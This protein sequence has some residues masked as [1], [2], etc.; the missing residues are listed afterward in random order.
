MTTILIIVGVIL[1]IFI[2]G[3]I[4]GRVEKYQNRKR[5]DSIRIPDT[6][7]SNI[8]TCSGVSEW[9]LRSQLADDPTHY[10]FYFNHFVF[11]HYGKDIS[12][13]GKGS[14]AVIDKLRES[15]VDGDTYTVLAE[16][17]EL[18]D[19]IGAVVQNAIIFSLAIGIVTSAKTPFMKQAI[20]NAGSL[21]GAGDTMTSEQ[22]RID[23][24]AEHPRASAIAEASA[25]LESKKVAFQIVG[26]MGYL[27][28]KGSAGGASET[29]Q[30]RIDRMFEEQKYKSIFQSEN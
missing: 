22:Y 6:P 8:K 2:I 5:A 28:D 7:L 24:L 20:S 9:I 25:H 10:R 26:M 1:A 19:E 15:I 3:G 21:Q 29:K 14:L 18:N 11:A 30:Q 27:V 17:D 4:W 23:M 12:S 16:V 13:L